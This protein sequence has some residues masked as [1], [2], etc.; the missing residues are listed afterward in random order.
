M[1]I[2]C[3]EKFSKIS[4]KVTFSQ[5]LQAGKSAK[6][7]SLVKMDFDM[8]QIENTFQETNEADK[9]EIIK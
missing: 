1:N 2:R 8:K 7:R 9:K 3:L 4:L 5:L 6:I